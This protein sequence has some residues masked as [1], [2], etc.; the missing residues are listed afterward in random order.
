MNNINEMDKNGTY[1]VIRLQHVSDQGG[2]MPDI[3]IIG[4]AHNITN[5]EKL[6]KDSVKKDLDGFKK[7][8]GA[9][10]T[11]NDYDITDPATEIDPDD[12][13]LSPEAADK[14]DA[15][16]G[17]IIYWNA[18][19]EKTYLKHYKGDNFV[20]EH[21]DGNFE[22]TTVICQIVPVSSEIINN[23]IAKA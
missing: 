21:D 13:Y 15:E 11:V 2:S 7:S 19:N 5:A 1:M 20:M 4:V 16:D 22:I 3:N 23:L 17:D 8:D 18:K 12:D 14:F 9:W 6:M 10:T